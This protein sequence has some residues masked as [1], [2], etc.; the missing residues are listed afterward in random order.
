MGAAAYKRV[1]LKIS[2]EALMGALASGT[3]P[4]TLN[5]IALQIK[6]AAVDLGVQVAVVVGG[7]NIWRGAAA[8]QTGMDRATADYAGMLATVINAL[9]LQDAIEQVGADV[10]TQTAIPVQQVAEPYIRRRAIRHLE[11]GRVVLFAAGTGNPFMTTDTAAAL[12]AIEIDAEVLLMTK[13]RVDGV[14]DADPLK[15]PNARRFTTLTYM[16]AISRRLEV[17]DSTALS[18]CMEN[19]LPILVFDVASPE[20]IVRAIRGEEIGTRVCGGD[21]ALETAA[22]RPGP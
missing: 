5:R 8:S 21:S 11:K 2:G 18:L 9:A 14:Y 17:M 15:H 20:G 7:G 6:T 3:D 13:N 1:L 22:A 16:D 12:R 10:R 19:D 4:A